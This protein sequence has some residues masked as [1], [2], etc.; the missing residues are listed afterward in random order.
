MARPVG[1]VLIPVKNVGD[2]WMTNWR[3]RR[4]EKKILFGHIGY[5]F[6]LRI[7]GEQM[8]E[9]LILAWT[10]FRRDCLPPLFGVV[11][12]RIDVEDHAAKWID[13][14]L[15]H[16]A[17]LVLGIFVPLR[18]P[19]KSPCNACL[20]RFMWYHWLSFGNTQFRQLCCQPVAKMGHHMAKRNLTD[21]TLKS[22]KAATKPGTHEDVWDLGFPGFGVRVSDTGRRTFVLTARYPGKNNPTRRALGVYDKTSLEGAREKARERLKLIA[23]GLTP[24]TAEEAARQAELR[25]I[26][27]TFVVVCEEFFKRHLSKT[28]QARRAELDIRR[29][30]VSRWADR[31]ITE[32]TRRDVLAV[33]DASVD[34]GNP[35]QAHNLLGC[36]R[37]IFNWAIARDVYGLVSLPCDRMRPKEIIGAKKVRTQASQ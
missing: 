10:D 36:I 16:L 30:F 26:E 27:N 28:R 15:H 32:I 24:E 14:V 35:Y 21:R 5:I 22:C 19:S 17:Y 34:R 4:I 23:R 3:T 1:P 7:F 29:E 18:F 2:V 11:E 6:S 20:S 12:H 9:R 25:K 8:I 13:A 37:R 33:I 31:P